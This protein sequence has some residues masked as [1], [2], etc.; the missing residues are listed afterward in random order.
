MRA[1]L[2]V[3]ALFVVLTICMTWPLVLHAGAS[4]EDLHDALLNTWILAWDGHAL[5]TDPAGLFDANI[6]YPYRDTLAFSEIILPQALMALPVTLASGNPV[7]GYNVALLASFVLCAFAAYLLVLRMTGSRWAGIAAG[8]VY[9]FNAYKMSN[10]AQAQLLAAQWLP[11]ALLYLERTLRPS[12]REKASRRSLVR[13]AALLALFVALQ[14]LSSFYYAIISAMAVVLAIVAALLARRVRSVA[15]LMRAGLALAMAA[16]LVLPFMLPYLR[17]ESTLGFRRALADSEPFSASLAQYVQALPGSVL[18]GD[19]AAQSP[20]AIGGYPLDSLFPGVITLLLALAGLL[21]WRRRVHL[22]L[23]PTLL[24]A[25]AFALSLGPAL[26]L[27]PGR[28]LASSPLMPYRLLY[29]LPGMQALRAPVRFSVLVFLGLS[30]L[31][32]LAVAAL[33]RGGRARALR[34]LAAAVLTGLLVADVACLNTARV[35]PVPVNAEVPDVYYWLAQQP[36]GVALELPMMGETPQRGLLTQY[37]SVYHWQRTPDGY[38]GFVPPKH[39]EIAYEMQSFPS[40]RSVSLLQGMGVHYV[41]VHTDLL[42]DW[43]TRAAGLASYATRIVYEGKFGEA[44]VYRVEPLPVRAPLQARLYLPDRS[45][46]GHDYVASLVFSGASNAPVVTPPTETVSVEAVWRIAGGAVVQRQSRQA[47]V[48]II[49][50]D[51]G[52]AQLPLDQP[53]DGVYSLTVNAQSAGGLTASDSVTVTIGGNAAPVARVIPARLLSGASDK[54]RYQPGDTVHVA[55]RWRALGKVDEYDSVFVRLLDANGQAVAQVDGQPAQGTKPTLLWTPGEE[56]SDDWTLIL[57]IGTPPGIYTLEAGLYLP[58]DLSPRLTL[59]GANQPVRRL[60]LGFVRVAQP[61]VRAGTP[62][63]PLDVA[64]G[65]RA[66]LLGYDI[67]GCTWVELNCHVA[68]GA[69]LKTTLYWR[70]DA[71]MTVDYTV[72]VHLADAANKPVAQHDARPQ[73]GAYPTTVWQRGDVVADSHTID[74]PRDAAGEFRLLVGLYDAASGVRVPA[75]TSGDATP[76]VTVV[77]R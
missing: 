74:V 66:T 65:D 18:Y 28:V 54:A 69:A 33:Q 50:T 44:I 15:A 10:L 45:S 27:E 40:E 22:W 60:L 46:G 71:E 21:A 42:A 3:L 37:L 30:V 57:P 9:A 24:A 72:F 70:A 32:G 17:V 5:L 43:T 41:V 19:L 53:A 2:V 26:L 7:L 13:S 39:G 29:L 64:F 31:A 49:V 34:W 20:V 77:V 61:L 73:G 4:V 58:A 36:D 11:L 62:P 12:S 16:L 59:D 48:P 56:I 76:L 67:E 6:F 25:G 63:L 52:V 14:A 75:G 51:V 35:I 47:A 23:F 68:L 8:I 1:A 38:S 55:L